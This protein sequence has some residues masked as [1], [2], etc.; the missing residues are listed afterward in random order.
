MRPGECQAGEK[1]KRAEETSLEIAK[2]KNLKKSKTESVFAL[3]K[4]PFGERKRSR[5]RVQRGGWDG[6]AL[7]QPFFKTRSVEGFI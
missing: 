5:I 3:L 2:A 1:R 4:K 7:V 6:G